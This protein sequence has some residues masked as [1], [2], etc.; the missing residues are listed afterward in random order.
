MFPLPVLG[1]K[2][3]RAYVFLV[4][5]ACTLAGFTL[6]PISISDSVTST[7]LRAK[8]TLA[9]YLLLGYQAHWP[10]PASASHLEQHDS[11]LNVVSSESIPSIPQHLPVLPRPPHTFRPDG[12]LQVNP[13]GRHP[14]LDLIDRAEE[15]WNGKLARASRTL[16]DA[17]REYHRRYARAPPPGF[18]K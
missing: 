3:F 1:R 11:H 5:F 16:P 9:P 12:L 17:V 18:D 6:S 8:K 10:D 7:P 4:A 13:N 2:S 14:I 15:E